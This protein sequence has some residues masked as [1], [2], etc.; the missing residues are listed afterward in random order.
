[1]RKKKSGK[2]GDFVLLAL[3]SSSSNPQS[4]SSS[5]SKSDR[6]HH[7]INP[8]YCIRPSTQ[9]QT[10]FSEFKSMELFKIQEPS[11]IKSLQTNI[12]NIDLPQS[13]LPKNDPHQLA[14]LLTPL[15]A[16]LLFRIDEI[17]GNNVLRVWEG[18][19][20]FTYISEDA[21]WV[22][23]SVHDTARTKVGTEFGWGALNHYIL[24]KKS[25][26]EWCVVR[27]DN[28]E[29]GNRQRDLKKVDGSLEHL[30]NSTDF[31]PSS[32]TTTTLI[33]SLKTPL[34]F[35]GDEEGEVTVHLPLS[36]PEFEWVFSHLVYYFD[37]YR[38]EQQRRD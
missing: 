15:S 37:H 23:V 12:Y 38:R 35:W 17:P 24:I 31:R 9:L 19:S 22:G 29:G 1:M 34:M 30:K 13:P 11:T 33:M 32:S 16:R 18:S 4:S 5:T 28:Y 26:K 2:K 21:P 10:S 6:K 20:R 7:H 3:P 25:M 27:S 8:I 36:L 14:T